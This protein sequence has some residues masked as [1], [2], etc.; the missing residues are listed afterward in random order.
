[1]FKWYLARVE[2]ETGKSMKCLRSKKGVEFISNE[3]KMFCNDRGIKDRH[4]HL[5]PLHKMEL[6]KEGTGL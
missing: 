2:Q 6:L 1:M 3:F 4:L 5:G